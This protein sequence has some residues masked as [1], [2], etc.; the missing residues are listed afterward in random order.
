MKNHKEVVQ[1]LG[2]FEKLFR[3]RMRAAESPSAIY[4]GVSYEM[5]GQCMRELWGQIVQLD[6]SDDEFNQAL[7]EAAF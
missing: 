2:E 5:L 7:K 4:E 3:Y 1:L 6:L